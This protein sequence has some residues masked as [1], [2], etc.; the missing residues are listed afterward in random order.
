VL[1]TPRQG[2]R[3]AR[4]PLERAGCNGPRP[5]WPRVPRAPAGRANATM[6][7]HRCKRT[8]PVVRLCD[9]RTP[10]PDASQTGAVET[11]GSLAVRQLSWE[12]SPACLIGPWGRV[13]LL[14]HLVGRC[15]ISHRL[16]SCQAMMRPSCTGCRRPLSGTS[17]RWLGRRTARRLGEVAGPAVSGGLPSELTPAQHTSPVDGLTRPPG[18]RFPNVVFETMTGPRARW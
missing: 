7:V 9:R 14:L 6:P 16:S 17:A 3:A 1:M 5:G 4:G 13:L 11:T 15:Q 12:T 2:A 8:Q 18:C 10:A